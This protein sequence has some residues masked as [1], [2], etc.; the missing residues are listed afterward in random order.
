MQLRLD[1][2]GCHGAIGDAASW[3]ASSW[4]PRFQNI[5]TWSLGWLGW[6]G[7]CFPTLWRWRSHVHGLD[8]VWCS[9]T[10]AHR[11][12]TLS[13]QM[14]GTE[15]VLRRCKLA[16]APFA[17]TCCTEHAPPTASNFMGSTVPAPL[18][19]A[20]ASFVV[21]H[22]AT[23]PSVR[24][25]LAPL[26][27]TLRAAALPGSSLLEQHWF[28]CSLPVQAGTRV[29]AMGPLAAGASLDSISAVQCRHFTGHSDNEAIS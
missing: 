7:V 17:T 27:A 16:H 29:R 28:V 20:T 14:A 8:V 25:L 12:S 26:L 6:L 23:A 24:Q 2:R 22:I 3:V 10:G 21:I 1:D 18:H 9:A 13:I 4:G 15:R 19:I 5:M 11:A